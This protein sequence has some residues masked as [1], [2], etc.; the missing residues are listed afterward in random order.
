MK[1]TELLN[2]RLIIVSGKG[3]VGKTSVSIL[4][5][6]LAAK[7]KK[8]TLIVEMNS[9]GRIAPI[10]NIDSLNH[11]E[12]PMAPYISGINLLPKHCFEEYVIKQIRFKLIYKTF[13][14][15]RFVTNFIDAIPGLSPILMLGKIFELE[16]QFKS[17]L[18]SQYAYDLII[19]DA[20]ATGHGL[21]A[22]EVPNVLKSAIKIG[23]LHKHA[24]NIL[25]LLSDKEK[26][27]F[28]LV[29]LAEEMPVNESEEYV[30]ALKQRTHMGFGPLFINAVMPEVK[31][32]K[33]I[34][35]LPSDLDIFWNYYHLAKSRYEL[36]Q[37]YVKEIYKKFPNMN[38]IIIPF[39]FHG[40][41]TQKSFQPL[42]KDLKEK[43]T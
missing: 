7:A 11:K 31:S 9:T 3:G 20:P 15:N 37:F 6:H 13:F 43:M 36:N 35:K 14:N 34:T 33:A 1:L 4:L 30:D 2:K 40:L 12:L 41:N 39:Q 42:I 25:D 18:K 21:S 8:K 23:P 24:S 10:F 26:T 22:L 29:T 32:I 38:P 17:K 27:C 28:C 5:A 16:G 19:V